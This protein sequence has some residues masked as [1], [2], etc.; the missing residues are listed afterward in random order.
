VSSQPA[1]QVERAESAVPMPDL[2]ITV[3]LRIRAGASA[4][5]ERILRAAAYAAVSWGFLYGVL[6]RALHLT[7][8]TGRLM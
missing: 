8:P 4:G 6:D 1:Q 5:R 7:L 3:V 2:I